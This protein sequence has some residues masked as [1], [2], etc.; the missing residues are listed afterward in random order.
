MGHSEVALASWPH[1][2]YFVASEDVLGQ[3]TKSF[4]EKMD[5]FRKRLNGKKE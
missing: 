5:G 1:A 4:N 2:R 3:Y